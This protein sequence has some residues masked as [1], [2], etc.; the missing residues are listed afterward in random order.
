MR[1]AAVLLAAFG[2]GVLLPAGVAGQQTEAREGPPP[3]DTLAA[4]QELSQG[5]FSRSESEALAAALVT[6]TEHLQTNAA[7][8]SLQSDIDARFVEMT[9]SIETGFARMQGLIAGV[10]T[11][12]ADR[13]NG[14]IMWV[15]GVGVALLGAGVGAVGLLLGVFIKRRRWTPYY[16]G[17]PDPP[18]DARVRDWNLDR[19]IDE[20]AFGLSTL[21]EQVGILLRKAPDDQQSEAGSEST[22]DDQR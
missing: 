16:D 19:R 14:V 5:G 1:V 4:T 22:P 17:D 21:Q 3:F 13:I 12:Q 18:Q 20:I 10:E 6:A 8:E 11:R 7:M 15:V 9:A 2:V